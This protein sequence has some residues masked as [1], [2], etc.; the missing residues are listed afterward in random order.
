MA[1]K[2]KITTIG[3]SIVNT[4]YGQLKGVDQTITL[5]CYIKVNAVSQNKTKSNAF[6]NYSDEA[7]QDNVLFFKNFEFETD[8]DGENS[9]KQAYLHLKTLPEFAGAIDC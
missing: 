7:N 6:V 2:Q 5:D 9:I 4:S 1:L 8:L 3:E